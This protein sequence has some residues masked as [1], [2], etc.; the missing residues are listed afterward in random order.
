MW[1][2]IFAVDPSRSR[3]RAGSC[4]PGNCTRIR[5]AP[6]RWIVGSATPTWSM[7]WRMISRLCSTA[8]FALSASPASV[9]ATVTV[10]PAPPKARSVA[11]ATPTGV[12][13][14][15]SAVRAA[16]RW[17]AEA[18]AMTSDGPLRWIVAFA[19]PSSRRTRLE[20]WTS[21]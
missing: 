6:T 9:R 2:L 14:V 15:P 16:A 18:S 10:G 20:S 12:A 17:S 8:A 3:I 5:S 19:I 4:T 11:P 7:R 1:K 21:V 13:S